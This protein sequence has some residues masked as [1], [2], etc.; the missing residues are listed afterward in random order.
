MDWS[1]TRWNIRTSMVQRISVGF[2]EWGFLYKETVVPDKEIEE[3]KT[4]FRTLL[5]SRT[6][7]F[8]QV[9]G[10]WFHLGRRPMPVGY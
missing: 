10:E 1:G 2:R 8:L 7:V 4:F 9:H 3:T 6:T 5:V